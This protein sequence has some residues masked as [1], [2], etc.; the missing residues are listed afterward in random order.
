M[1]RL[2]PKSLFGQTL[3]I[4]L[5]GLVASHLVGGWIYATDRTQAVRA[6][7]GLAMAQRVVN[8]VRL[9]E[10][11]AA[12]SRDRV[13]AV[14]SD[15]SFRVA[16]S[17]AAP[18]FSRGFVERP[19]AL[20]V[21]SYI[22]ARLADDGVGGQVRVAVSGTPEAFATTSDHAMQMGAMMG[23]LGSWREMQIAVQLRPEE[24]WLLITTAFPDTGPA[25]SGQF[26]LS[27]AAMAGVVFVVSI[28]AV[29]RVT[30]PLRELS[31]AAQR[32]GK[33]LASP[34]V[35]EHGTVEM[36]AAAHA[37][38]E[39]QDRLRSFV[40][41]R[42]RMLAAISHDLRT[43]L[44][45]LRLRAENVEN[46]DDRD[47]MLA[48]IGSM[49]AMIEATLAFARNEA[50][51]EPRRTIDLAA[52]IA[53]IVD[54]MAESGA[55][56]AMEASEQVIYECQPSALRR[57]ITNLLDNAVK[58]GKAAHAFLRTHADSI[59]I[60]VDDVG[61]GIPEE[62]LPRVTQ[63]F[64]RLDHSRAAESGGIGLGLAI[65]DAVVRAHGGRL[66][67]ANGKEGGLRAVVTL[68]R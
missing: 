38:N 52:L 68:P 53:S 15:P 47:R 36:R 66:T 4:L 6:V 11:T 46:R 13:A 8:V 56:V 10:G 39:M 44:T 27:M 1:I 29:R 61:P 34:P 41:N 65:T 17:G 3:L 9:I 35:A 37:F 26:F 43:P 18:D 2:F 63:P 23:E 31:A 25:L 55:P 28:W 19:V 62:E 60:T 30:T 5:V 51:A 64:Y 40:E 7:G 22:G 32:L 33:D 59:E 48:T 57:A 42:T 50:M 14:A 67:L 24:Q 16:L 20:A 58:Y 49:N 21:K 45:L 12:S 54:D